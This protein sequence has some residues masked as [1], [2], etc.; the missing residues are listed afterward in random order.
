MQLSM[1]TTSQNLSLIFNSIHVLNLN[2]H[3]NDADKPSLNIA[4]LSSAI[5]FEK[6]S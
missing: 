3:Y 2:T 5:L 4:P 1:K 6:E